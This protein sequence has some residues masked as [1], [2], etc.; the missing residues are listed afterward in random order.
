MEIENVDL[1]N[2]LKW[3]R[4]RDFLKSF[5]DEEDISLEEIVKSHK[6]RKQRILDIEEQIK[7]L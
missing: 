7:E 4:I 3:K 5:R 6:E 2:K 1:L